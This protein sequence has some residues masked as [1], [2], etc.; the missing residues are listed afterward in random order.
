MGKECYFVTNYVDRVHIALYWF[1][2]AL[3][4]W[5]RSRKTVNE[6]IIKGK[7]E[8][9]MDLQVNEMSGNLEEIMKVQKDIGSVMKEEG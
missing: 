8:E 3:L 6:T 7:L 5:T 9:L 2:N 1:S 4:N